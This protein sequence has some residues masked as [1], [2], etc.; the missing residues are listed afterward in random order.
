MNYLSCTCTHLCP[1]GTMNHE[2]WLSSL[3]YL[4]CLLVHTTGFLTDQAF[5]N[6]G[7]PMGQWLHWKYH[8]TWFCPSTISVGVGVVFTFSCLLACLFAYV[9]CFLV[10]LLACLFT[11]FAF[12]FH[13]YSCFYMLIVNSFTCFVRRLVLHETMYDSSSELGKVQKG[14]YN[15]HYLV[16]YHP[17]FVWW[18]WYF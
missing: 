12:I 1:V 13:F 6:M 2:V 8:F 16:I 7:L 15:Y 11:F 17:A 18:A 3:L 4:S 9:L 10:C 14:L 5:T